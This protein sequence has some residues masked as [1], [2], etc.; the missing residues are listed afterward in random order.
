M[1]YRLYLE[2]LYHQM[3]DE[4]KRNKAMKK[5]PTKVVSSMAMR[6]GQAIIKLIRNQDI[7]GGNGN[8]KN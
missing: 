3:M 8:G 2:K 6:R 5:Q 1:D 7:K 4:V